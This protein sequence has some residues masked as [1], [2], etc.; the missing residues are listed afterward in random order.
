MNDFNEQNNLRLLKLFYEELKKTSGDKPFDKERNLKILIVVSSII[1]EPVS[2]DK[3]SAITSGY[4][5]NVFFEKIQDVLLLLANKDNSSQLESNLDD[6]FS[7]LFRYVLEVYLSN[8]SVMDFDAGDI[9]DFAIQN[10][11]KFSR[12]ASDSISY[13]LNSLPI[14]ILKGI[15]NDSEFKTLS[16]FIG[17]LK[18]S[19]LTM[20]N[21][22]SESKSNI[23]KERKE[24]SNVIDEMKETTIKKDAEWKEFINAKVNDVDAIRESLNHYHNAFNF[25]GLFDG[26]KELSNEKIKE[27]ERS[28]YLVCILAFITLLPLAYEMLHLSLNKS[29]YSSLVDYLSLIPIFSVTV[30]LIYYFKI[31]LQNYNSIKAQ[32]AQIEL[33]KTLCR[34]IQDYGDYSVKM[35]KQDPES[36][37]KFEN[38]IFSSIITN[39]DNIPATFDGL[40]QIAKIIGNLKGSK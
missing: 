40:E 20:D 14:G 37:S 27:K 8:S 26:F 10:K 11:D 29:S 24:L 9:R 34:F 21:F 15:I 23:E 4:I 5:S 7:Y 16:E 28:F 2:W 1:S 39:G 3:N 38:I 25:V 30:I 22:T 6:V 12:K 36:L 31:A 32:L 17:I 33:R 18:N 13:S 35:K 19:K